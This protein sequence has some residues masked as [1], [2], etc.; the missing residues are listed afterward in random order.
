MRLRQDNNGE[1]PTT[2]KQSKHG[3]K[4]GGKIPRCQIVKAQVCWK[5]QIENEDCK[6]QSEIEKFAC[7]DKNWH[8]QF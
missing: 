4:Y 1:Q 7:R 6:M 3:D 8:L 5:T 2:P